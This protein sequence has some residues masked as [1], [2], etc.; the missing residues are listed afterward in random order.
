MT[1]LI[2][3]FILAGLA[4]SVLAS[5][6]CEEVLPTATDDGLFPVQPRTVE[7]VV[8]YEAFVEEV[9]IIGGFG[10][11]SDLGVGPV[12]RDFEGLDSRVILRHLP[13][14]TVATVP[15]S[16]GVNRPDTALA[17]IGGRV[18]LF[19]DSLT[20][21]TEG[22]VRVE[23]GATT[24]PWHSPTVSWAQRVDTI[25]D[26]SEWSV[27]G[28][29]ELEV[30]GE[31]T[32][33]RETGDSLSIE[34]DSAQVATLSDSTNASRGIVVRALDPGRRLDYTSSRLRVEVRPSINQ[35]TILTFSMAP[36]DISFLYD[37]LPDPPPDGL[38]VGGAPAWRTFL[39]L[40][41]LDVITEG[42]LCEEVECPFRINSDQ[43]NQAELVLTTRRSELAFQPTTT[44]RL[45]VRFVVLPELLPK[46][47][48][49]PPLA[50]ENGRAGLQ[51]APELFGEQSGTQIFLPV[52]SFYRQLLD[53]ETSDGSEVPDMLALLS[54]NEPVS[55]GFLSFE[56]EGSTIAPPMLRLVLT[57]SGIV[58]LP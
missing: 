29:G 24:E 36:Q 40:K 34:I 42:P 11:P 16:L 44:T 19:F 33:S 32:V 45:D 20:S 38:R 25:G 21:Q 41:P 23:V 47:P 7:F 31:G 10:S 51:M 58:E 4:G 39:T 27:P 17:F 14:P 52:T 2:Q 18:V 30:L 5:A 9:G 50:R 49:G 43:V 37:P 55:L 3:R 6:G 46:S 57:V 1:S 53:G 12:A 22:G 13:P 56:G 8:P 48:L 15:D 54:V 35:D 28:G 26:R